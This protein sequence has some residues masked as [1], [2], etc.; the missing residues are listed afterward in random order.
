M[1]KLSTRR[2]R[3]SKSFFTAVSVEYTQCEKCFIYLLEDY[4]SPDCNTIAQFRK[5]HRLYAVATLLGQMVKLLIQHGE[6]S[7]EKSAVFIDDTR[8]KV[9]TNL[10]SFVWKTAVTKHQAKPSKELPK[11]LGSSGAGSVMPCIIT[12]Q[13]LKEL[14]KSLYAKRIKATVTF[15][16]EKKCHKA[17]L[18]KVK[19]V[20]L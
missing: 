4:T 6:I 2:I 5:K 1:E 11:L 15:L 17:G 19:K 12:V 10:H 16:R 14:R 13:K 7:F 20:C 8:I 9:N 18:Q 3:F